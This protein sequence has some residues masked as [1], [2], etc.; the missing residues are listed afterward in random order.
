MLSGRI[1]L[2]DNSD[3]ISIQ[4]ES[5]I[6]RMNRQ[7]QI[8]MV[9]TA[10]QA[11]QELESNRYD[12][13]IMELVL[14]GTTGVELLEKVASEYPGSIRMVLSASTDR[15]MILQT[16]GLAHRF[17]AKPADAQH[18]MGLLDTSINLREM[19]AK[20]ELHARIAKIGSLPSAPGI[21]NELITQLRNDSC[22][23][24]DVAGIIA[25]DLAM[26]AKILQMVNSAYFGLP[27]RISSVLQAVNMM[28]L[29]TVKSVA[30]TA[31][32]FSE[33]NNPS[34]NC[35]SLTIDSLF[36]HSVTVGTNAQKVA[37]QMGLPRYMC[38][39]ALMAGMLHDIG[40]LVLMS[41]FPEE[42]STSI[43]LAVEKSWSIEKAQERIMGVTHAEI[44]AHLLSL[45]GLSDQILEAVALHPS[46]S[47]MPC[48]TPSVLTAVHVANGVYHDTPSDGVE[49]LGCCYDEDYLKATHVFDQL[50]DLRSLCDGVC[51]I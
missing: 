49:V 11:L 29:E 41:N 19:F 2:V 4:L 39:D 47:R 26:T 25:N 44:G 43:E 30:M 50:E 42:L 10:A 37:T 33:F 40:K 34:I 5:E 14:P 23:I 38:D 31:G 51:E 1:L 20:P 21:Y 36:H 18:L 35:K 24:K 17:I 28:G 9:E 6:N 15:Q 16:A 48:P 45:W 7:W 27:S 12:I 46:P 13:V 3:Q 8:K 32:V 22:S